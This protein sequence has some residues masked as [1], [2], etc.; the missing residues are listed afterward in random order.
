M[1]FFGGYQKPGEQLEQYL[2]GLSASHEGIKTKQIVWGEVQLAKVCALSAAERMHIPGSFRP[3][4]IDITTL[5]DKVI[6][7]LTANTLNTGLEYARVGYVDQ[8]DG[9]TPEIIAELYWGRVQSGDRKK[10]GID[11]SPQRGVRFTI[12]VAVLHSHPVSAVDKLGIPGVGNRFG[13]HLSP[14]DYVG[15]LLTPELVMMGMSWGDFV[16]IALKTQSAQHVLDLQSQ[17]E[18]RQRV[19]EIVQQTGSERKIRGIPV[20][21]VSP[22]R[23]RLLTKEVCLQFGLVLYYAEKKSPLARL[24]KMD[25]KHEFVIHPRARQSRFRR[26]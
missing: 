13:L 6:S 16:L 9:L 8:T 23:C 25:D 17:H 5:R 10:V 14:E 26:S 2:T 19:Q 21:I 15:F 11:L 3:D 18:T 4:I 7:G 1:E 22:E 20:T 24:V 12:P